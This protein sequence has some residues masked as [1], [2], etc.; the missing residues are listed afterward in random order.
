MILNIN[1]VLI[2][3][4]ILANEYARK[5]KKLSNVIES[6]VEPCLMFLQGGTLISFWKELLRTIY[7][8]NAVLEKVAYNEEL[9]ECITGDL[10]DI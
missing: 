5:L 6:N 10:Q 1:T 9:M 4:L 2:M 8:L 3:W 7:K